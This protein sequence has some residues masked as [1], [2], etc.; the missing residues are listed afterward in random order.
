MKLNKFTATQ[1]LLPFRLTERQEDGTAFELEYREPQEPILM[2]LDSLDDCTFA[3]SLGSLTPEGIQWLREK[4][5]IRPVQKF[6][7]FLRA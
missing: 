2:E 6:L 3:W 7:E 1:L 4:A 5:H